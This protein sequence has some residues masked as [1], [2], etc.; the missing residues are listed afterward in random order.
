MSV[1][2][3]SKYVWSYIWPVAESLERRAEWHTLHKNFKDILKFPRS[4]VLF[5]ELALA[6]VFESRCWQISLTFCVVPNTLGLLRQNKS[7][8]LQVMVYTT[9][10][11]YVNFKLTLKYFTVKKE[12]SLSTITKCICYMKINI[13][14]ISRRGEHGAGQTIFSQSVNLLYRNLILTL[15]MSRSFGCHS[16]HLLIFEK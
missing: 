16:I 8:R 5:H 12:K 11:Y 3:F 9:L 7:S 10:F 13:L 6:L 4:F 2:E 15:D 1:T 14:I